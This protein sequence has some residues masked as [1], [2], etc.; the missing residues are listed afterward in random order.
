M[1][2]SLR[3]STVLPAA[4][5]RIYRA[6]LDAREHGAF[7]GGAAQVDPR[8]GGRFSL[9]DGYIEGTTLE[10]HEGRSIVQSWRTTEIPDGQAESYRQGWEECYLTPMREYFGAP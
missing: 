2:E 5:A 7:S 1:S 4:P 6:W 8:V 10:L 9:W 3:L